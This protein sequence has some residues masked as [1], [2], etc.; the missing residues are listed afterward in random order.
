M[1]F[2]QVPNLRNVSCGNDTSPYESQ[3]LRKP[4]EYAPEIPGL[5]GRTSSL[6]N[7]AFNQRQSRCGPVPR[8]ETIL[9][10]AIKGFCTL[11]NTSA[12]RTHVRDRPPFLRHSVL[13]LS[14]TFVAE[15]EES[16]VGQSVVH[17]YQSKPGCRIG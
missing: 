17:A 12:S 1:F 3:D 2:N 7:Q 9:N 5:P 4:H 6:R 13:K 11:Q 10:T 14:R 15:T 8:D 16:V